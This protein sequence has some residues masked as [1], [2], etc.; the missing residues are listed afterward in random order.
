MPDT[1]AHSSLS[2]D[3]WF[4]AQAVIAADEGYASERSLCNGHDAYK[5]LA[6]D[7]SCAHMRLIGIDSLQWNDALLFSN[8][9]ETWFLGKGG[10][11]MQTSPGTKH[12]Q[13][14]KAPFG[15]WLLPAHQFAD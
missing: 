6:V 9:G 13:M 11:N 15:H 1:G 2:G 4:R 14:V 8:T 5:E 3:S 7:R 10:V 12:F